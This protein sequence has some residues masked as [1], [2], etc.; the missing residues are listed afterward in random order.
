[1]SEVEIGTLDMRLTS[2]S[3]HPAVIGCPSA[4]TPFDGPSLGNAYREESDLRFPNLPLLLLLLLLLRL[5]GSSLLSVL[6]PGLV[7]A[8]HTVAGGIT[9]D[10]WCPD[11]LLYVGV[12]V[13]RVSPLV[14]LLYMSPLVNYLGDSLSGPSVLKGSTKGQILCLG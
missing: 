14:P 11:P 7:H 5:F 1:M 13:R 2:L 4:L 10:P 8:L 9:L 6:A 12:V 3:A